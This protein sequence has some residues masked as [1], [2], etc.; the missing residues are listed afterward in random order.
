MLTMIAALLIAA[1]ESGEVEAARKALSR[2]LGVPPDALKVR[3]S[4][5]MQWPDSSL[6][7]PRKGEKYLQMVT[8]GREVVLE[9][10]GR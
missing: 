5:P 4:K 6:G 8:K 1:A 2:E 3:S 10:G 7:C 9:S